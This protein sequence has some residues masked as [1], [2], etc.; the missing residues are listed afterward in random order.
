MFI[1]PSVLNEALADMGLDLLSEEERN[2]LLADLG[3]V[4]S[5]AVLR[6]VWE[7]LTPELQDELIRLFEAGNAESDNTKSQEQVDR[8]FKE[9]VPDLERFI[10]EESESLLAAQRT[11]YEE[12]AP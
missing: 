1:A 8:F 7:T 10:K 2:E 3:E 5:Q 12:I 11:T 4:L 9:H 6:R